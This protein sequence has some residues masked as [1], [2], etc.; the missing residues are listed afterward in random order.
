MISI[1]VFG[2]LAN[3]ILE[4][5]GVVGGGT[6]DQTQSDRGTNE[7]GLLDVLLRRTSSTMGASLMGPDSE[8][9]HGADVSLLTDNGLLSDDGLLVGEGKSPTG[10]LDNHFVPRTSFEDE[11]GEEGKRAA[12]QP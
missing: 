9:L 7:L 10:I 6:R 11:Q 3:S 12:E 4:W 2:G 8:A 1:F 5:C